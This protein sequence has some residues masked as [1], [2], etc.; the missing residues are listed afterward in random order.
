MLSLVYDTVE[1]ASFIPICSYRKLTGL[2]LDLFSWLFSAK[3][4]CYDN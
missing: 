4:Y 3:S 2:V 1:V